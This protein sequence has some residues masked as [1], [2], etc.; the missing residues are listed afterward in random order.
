MSRIKRP[1][2]A[3]VVAILALVAAI[4]VPAYALTK[5][6]KR[7]V[8]KISKAQANKQITKRAPRL[9]VSNSRTTNEVRQSER[10]VM[11]DP[12]PGDMEVPT[13]PSLLTVGAFTIRAQ[14]SQDFGG[15]PTDAASILLN[16][17]AQSSF[18]G[19]RSTTAVPPEVNVENTS[20]LSLGV[21]SG[22]GNEVGSLHL[23]ALAPN[24]QIVDV[25]ASAEINDA[26]GDCV[27]GVTATGP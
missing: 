17:P 21:A 27:F 16:G 12:V 11:E 25:S 8:R 6:E 9:N 14:C 22:T 15:G 26:A 10:L 13:S 2:P 20:G 19:L 7:V 3:L 5:G 4:G 18:S 1:S 24:G 23:V